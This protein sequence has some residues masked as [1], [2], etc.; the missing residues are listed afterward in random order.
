VF[1]VGE[2]AA[3]D[4]AL[5]RVVADRGHEIGLHNWSHVQLT[6]QTP[7]DFRAGV[8]RGKALLED[9][10]GREVL[11]F[12]APTGSLVPASRWAVDVLVDEGFAYSSSVC[13]GRNPINSY[14]GAPR[15]PFRYRTGLL[16][17]PAPVA[18]FGPLQIPYLG[19]T[20]LRV[21]PR[22]VHRVLRAVTPVPDAG[23]IYCHPYDFDPDEPFWWVAD[24]G[25]LSPLLWWGRDGLIPKL[26][27]L[28]T[29]GTAPPLGEQLDRARR[30]PVFDPDAT[31]AR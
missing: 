9:I 16:E 22:P 18:G 4:P 7:D 31:H 24:V 13:P 26:E 17:F 15:E 5:V 11:G 20:Y 12:R 28:T 1:V 23:V 2:L 8:R 6:T 21:L 10:T 14:P 25:W 3:A 29:D 30:G 27:R 19:G